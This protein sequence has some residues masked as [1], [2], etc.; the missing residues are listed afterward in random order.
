MTTHMPLSSGREDDMLRRLLPRR[1]QPDRAS[2]APGRSKPRRLRRA[3]VAAP[4]ASRRHKDSSGC[5]RQPPLPAGAEAVVGIKELERPARLGGGVSR[6]K[7]AGGQVATVGGATA[8]ALFGWGGR[9]QGP[10]GAAIATAL[11]RECVDARLNVQRFS[12]EREPIRSSCELGGPIMPGSAVCPCAGE[13]RAHHQ[14]ACA[15]KN[16]R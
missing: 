9:A 13:C 4:D 2:T 7:G 3:A 16:I 15:P 1:A 12:A 6:R 8:C 11:Q 10:L 5:A 14:L